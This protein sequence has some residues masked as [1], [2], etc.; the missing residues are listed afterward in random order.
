MDA[1]LHFYRV[2]ALEQTTH[3]TST[4]V[5]TPMIA[6]PP[7]FFHDRSHSGLEGIGVETIIQGLAQA[8]GAW[9]GTGLPCGDAVSRIGGTTGVACVGDAGKS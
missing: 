9:A 8:L 6:I 2:S 3:W 5:S 4:S 7:L 1:F